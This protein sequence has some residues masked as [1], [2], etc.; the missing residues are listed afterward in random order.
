[1]NTSPDEFERLFVNFQREAFRL[2]TLD[3]YSGSSDPESQRAFHAGEPQPADYNQEWADEV[4]ANVDAGKRMYRVHIMSR[5]LTGYLR[6]ELGWGYRKNVLAGE[7]FFI[8]DITERPNPLA[9]V[10]DF[11]MFDESSVFSMNYGD[12][13]KFLGVMSHSDVSQWIERRDIALV[14]AV[15]FHEWWERYGAE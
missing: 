9:G 3:D 11:W 5:P 10:P 13:G 12:H 8:L 14:H 2:E 4:R 7:E 1:M 6:F 15:P